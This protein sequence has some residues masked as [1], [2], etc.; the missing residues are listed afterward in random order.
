MIACGWCG[1]PTTSLERCSHCRHEDPAKPWV[2]RGLE[3]PT[4]AEIERAAK[5]LIAARQ[6]VV[7]EVREAYAQLS[8]SRELGD[9]WRARILPPLEDDIRGAERAYKAGD[10]S[11]LFTLE[12]TRRLTDARLRETELQAAAARS[13]VALERSVGRRLFAKR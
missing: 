9:L 2:Q 5:Q 11:Y 1:E 4:H 7:A 8:Q 10:V 13:L 3:P 6:R 12:T